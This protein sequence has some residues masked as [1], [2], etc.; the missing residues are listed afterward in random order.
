MQIDLETR[1]GLLPTDD[2]NS[3]PDPMIQTWGTHTQIQVC[4]NGS[5][6]AHRG[7]VPSLKHQ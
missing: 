2:L 6:A 5:P 1:F 3:V 4:G 7:F